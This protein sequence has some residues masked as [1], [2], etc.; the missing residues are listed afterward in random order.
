M[1]EV[2]HDMNIQLTKKLEEAGYEN[3]YDTWHGENTFETVP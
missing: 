1:K 3:S 2:A